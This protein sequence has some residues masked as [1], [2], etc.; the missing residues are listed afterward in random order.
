MRNEE[1]PNK[2]VHA[3]DLASALAALR[4]KGTV[5]V[6]GEDGVGSPVEMEGGD[7]GYFE[8]S[9]SGETTVVYHPEEHGGRLDLPAVT[10]ED[11]GTSSVGS[12]QTPKLD[13][14][15]DGDQNMM[16]GH[17]GSAGG[18]GRII[19]HTARPPVELMDC[20]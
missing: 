9:R 5:G 14:D 3:D 19:A 7:R 16:G 20:S 6:S 8:R 11:T 18:G 13:I 4:S 15:M 10:V 12:I 1:P 2:A 17:Y